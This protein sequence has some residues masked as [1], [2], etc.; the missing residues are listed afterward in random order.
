MREFCQRGSGYVARE[1][2]GNHLSDIVFAKYCGSRRE[3]KELFEGVEFL[4]ICCYYC[5]LWCVY[6]GRQGQNSYNLFNRPISFST[7]LLGVPQYSQGVLYIIS[8]CH[9]GNA[10]SR[11]TLGVG[12]ENS[13]RLVQNTKCLQFHFQPHW[14][15]SISGDT[16]YRQLELHQWLDLGQSQ[17]LRILIGAR[18]GVLYAARPARFIGLETPVRRLSSTHKG[19]SRYPCSAQHFTVRADGSAHPTLMVRRTRSNWVQGSHQ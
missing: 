1:M 15:L 8:S 6:D 9:Y 7:T 2:M 13:L 11:G 18:L 14:Q 16:Q 17:I 3:R 19:R 5:L 4:P 10:L 12:Q